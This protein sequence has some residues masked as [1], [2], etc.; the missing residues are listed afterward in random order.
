MKKIDGGS[1]ELLV[2]KVMRVIVNE[3]REKREKSREIYNKIKNNNIL[4]C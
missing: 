3:E 2:D 4:F 1:D